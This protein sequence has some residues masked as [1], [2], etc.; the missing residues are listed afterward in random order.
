[1]KTNRENVISIL[2]EFEKDGN[3][4]VMYI[5][6]NHESHTITA[7]GCCNAGIVPEVIM[8]LDEDFS[9]DMNIQMLVEEL[10]SDGYVLVG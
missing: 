1:M 10:E 4:E 8:D 6:I 5:D 7:G 9:I 3:V 2:G